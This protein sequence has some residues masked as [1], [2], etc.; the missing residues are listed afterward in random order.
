[1]LTV[2]IL[3]VPP[4]NWPVRGSD[5]DGYN[6]H[7]IHR[8]WSEGLG[9]EVMSFGLE[10]H[11]DEVQRLMKEMGLRFSDRRCGI[12]GFRTHNKPNCPTNERTQIIMGTEK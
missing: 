2:G 12:C 11:P 5:N 1:M 8:Y 7:W 10:I 9:M 6:K 3:Q 4:I